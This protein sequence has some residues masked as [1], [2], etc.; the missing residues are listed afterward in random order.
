MNGEPVRCQH[1]REVIG[2]YE[3]MVALVEDVPVQISRSVA[4][5]EQLA[6]GRCY[7]TSCFTQ[8]DR[9]GAPDDA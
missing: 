1:C 4:E 7:H 2:A 8:Q 6:G 5:A 9:P 3:P